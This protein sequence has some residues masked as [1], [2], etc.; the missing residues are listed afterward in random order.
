MK[1]IQRYLLLPSSP[2]CDFLHRKHRGALGMNLLAPML[3]APQLHLI[4]Q[5][6]SSRLISTYHVP[7]AVQN[8]LS[9]QRPSEV[10]GTIVI[11]PILEVRKLRYK[12]F[13]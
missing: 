3:S 6:Q 8:M 11:I 2:H 9:S 13:K 5:L 4:R 1:L 12:E 10:Q 7:G